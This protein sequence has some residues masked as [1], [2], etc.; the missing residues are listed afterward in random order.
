MGVFTTN[1]DAVKTP[2]EA[3]EL[4]GGRAVVSSE[5]R[6]HRIHGVCGITEKEGVLSA[7]K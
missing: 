1:A 4:R 2:V 5:S 3:R 7:K 6:F